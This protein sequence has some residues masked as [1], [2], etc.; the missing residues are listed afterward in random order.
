[1][2]LLTFHHIVFD[3]WSIGIF[4]R[5]LATL[6]HAY[7]QGEPSSLPELPIQYTDYAA[8]QRERLQGEVLESE[9]DYWKQQLANVPVVLDL[10]RDRPRPAVQTYQG[11]L[12]T[13]K[14]PE[15]LFHTLE[16]LSRQESCTLF[17]MLLAAFQVLLYRYTG[18]HDIVVGSPVANRSHVEVEKLI[19]FFANTLVLRSDLSGNPT[20]RELLNRV[21]DMTLDAYAHQE[22][23][24]EKLVN[25]LNSPDVI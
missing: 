25:E 7:I 22:M 16:A 13:F 3:G 5:E 24:F 6:Y 11:G 14:L 9:L 21:R 23:P 15:E 12:H 2:L 8:W 20:F 1:M 19:G 18:Q 17:Q 4:S 10:P